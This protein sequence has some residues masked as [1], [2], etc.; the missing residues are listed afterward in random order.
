MSRR[1][2]SL[3][4]TY[5]E[6]YGIGLSNHTTLRA[7]SAL[8]LPD[9]N[10]VVPDNSSLQLVED[11]SGAMDGL[12]ASCG[13]TNI[14]PYSY[15]QPGADNPSSSCSYHPQPLHTGSNTD[16]PHQLQGLSCHAIYLAY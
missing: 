5:E 14:E 4:V 7:H 10:A 15:N 12:T 2:S 8:R 3:K 9:E 6:L 1:I 13:C 16:I 11:V